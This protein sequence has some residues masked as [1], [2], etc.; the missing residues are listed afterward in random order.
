MAEAKPTAGSGVPIEYRTVERVAGPL[1]FV[2]DVAYA[3]YV[4][5]VDIE[6]TE[7]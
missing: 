2:R 1:L 6:L 3:A 4:L 5:L 7:V